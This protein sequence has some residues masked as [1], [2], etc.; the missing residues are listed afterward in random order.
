[1]YI[2]VAKNLQAVTIPAVTFGNTAV[3]IF[4]IA[5]PPSNFGN[6][7]TYTYT[8]ATKTIGA[9]VQSCALSFSIY[10]GDTTLPVGSLKATAFI[11]TVTIKKAVGGAVLNTFTR[12]FRN[13]VIQDVSHSYLWVTPS[14]GTAAQA[15]IVDVNI[16]VD[17]A[18]SAAGSAFFLNALV[19]YVT[20][21]MTSA[22]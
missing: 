7:L 10:A 21:T 16:A 18:N 17:A 11:A 15:I 6:T 19:S 1:V 3:Q 9:G 20:M 2:F 14:L 5:G 4:D 22:I 8:S 12:R 13:Y